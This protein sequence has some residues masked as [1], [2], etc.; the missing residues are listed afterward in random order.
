M[1]PQWLPCLLAAIYCLL[2]IVNWE[3]GPDL[4]PVTDG[5]L[6]Y[7]PVWASNGFGVSASGNQRLPPGDLLLSS[8]TK[9]ETYLDQLVASFE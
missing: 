7:G 6:A 5:L 2:S 8:S 9:I 3:S 1:G 4:L